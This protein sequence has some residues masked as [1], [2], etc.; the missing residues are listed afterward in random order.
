MGP[1]QQKDSSDEMQRAFA[2]A[3]EA[4]LL[5]A[6]NPE[7]DTVVLDAVQRWQDPQD[8]ALHT[9]S[10]SADD[11]TQTAPSPAGMRTAC[12][13]KIE[14]QQEIT[15]W[16]LPDDRPVLVGRSGKN[17]SPLDVDLWPD[18]GVSRRHAVI[19]FDGEGWRIEDLRSKNG[20][21]LGE[22]NIRGQRA[23]RLEPGTRLQ[24]G[25]TILVLSGPD[26]V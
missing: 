23:I 4:W 3:A 22:N 10:T 15:V 11:G 7:A 26:D 9:T 12:L 13:V 14:G 18:P 16:L 8:D 20:T 17:T 1:P 24:I 5:R 21:V 2:D 25:G 19:W 6:R